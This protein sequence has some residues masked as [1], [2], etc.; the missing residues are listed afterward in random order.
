MHSTFA[1]QAPPTP[2]CPDEGRQ[3]GSG[4]LVTICQHQES[5]GVADYLS[6]DCE[7]MQIMGSSWWAV[8]VLSGILAL[9]GLLLGQ[10]VVIG[11]ERWKAK[12]EDLH[13]WHDERLKLY[14]DFENAF[15]SFREEVAQF[16]KHGVERVPDLG[17]ENA[18]PMFDLTNKMRLI[19]TKPVNDAA[20]TVWATSFCYVGELVGA[21]EDHVNSLDGDGRG[22]FI[23]LLKENPES[24]LGFLEEVT[25]A[26]GEDMSRASVAFIETVRAE[27]GVPGS[28]APPEWRRRRW[29]TL[30]RLRARRA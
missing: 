28:T 29:F 20:A 3:D 22:E 19:S 25:T 23:E 18:K 15:E 1:G 26:F 30:K 21:F 4:G 17:I 12:R 13:R 27:L 7:D 5:V 6:S 16:L 14:L 8:P 9:A 2:R 11:N 24:A 10:A